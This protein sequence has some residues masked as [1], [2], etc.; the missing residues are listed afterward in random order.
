[1]RETTMKKTTR[2]KVDHSELSKLG[3]GFFLWLFAEGLA[4]AAYAT[5]VLFVGC[6]SDGQSFM[7]A[8]KFTGGAAVIT[9]FMTMKNRTYLQG[10]SGCVLGMV[11]YVMFIYR[12]ECSFLY[13]RFLFFFYLIVWVGIVLYLWM[14]E[15]KRQSLFAYILSRT[16]AS[17]YFSRMLLAAVGLIFCIF[18]VTA[19]R[20]QFDSFIVERASHPSYLEEDFRIDKFYGEEYG[21]EKNENRIKRAFDENVWSELTLAQKQ[22]TLV[23]VIEYEAQK[24]GI[25]YQVT[26]RFSDRMRDE[27]LGE[28]CHMYR[29]IT[30]NNNELKEYGGEKCFLTAVHEIRHCYQNVLADACAQLSPRAR[31]LECFREVYDWG[32]SFSNYDTVKTFE[33]Y[34]NQPVEKDARS[35]AEEE[36]ENLKSLLGIYDSEVQSDLP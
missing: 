35:Y 24:L 27:K 26:V 34:F 7:N 22:D 33:E 9:F 32:V 31:G 36:L 11:G 13:N 6:V 4:L 18:I 28:Y 1:M 14:G 21:L 10:I 29:L 23:A 5:N 25:P 3:Y 8:L 19:Y 17:L 2:K 15:R 12:N 30:I 20:E 16:F